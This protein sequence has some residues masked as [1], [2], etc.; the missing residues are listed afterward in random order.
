MLAEFRVKDF[1]SLREEAVISFIPSSRLRKTKS[2]IE[3]GC[4]EIPSLLPFLL[5][6]GDETEG[7]NDL[8]LALD[9]FFYYLEELDRHHKKGEDIFDTERYKNLIYFSNKFPRFEGTF[10]IEDTAIMVEVSVEMIHDKMRWKAVSCPFFYRLKQ[11]KEE[12]DFTLSKR[13]ITIHDLYPED[14]R[15]I[16]LL[17]V[18]KVARKDEDTINKTWEEIKDYIEFRKGS[19]C[20]C[21]TDDSSLMTKKEVRKDMIYFM[22]TDHRTMTTEVYSLMQF[23]EEKGDCKNNLAFLYEEGI[24]GAVPMISPKG[25]YDW[26][27]WR[28][29]KETTL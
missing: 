28:S 21:F 5:V 11:P 13:F 24:Y 19:Q 12:Q 10:V 7:R 25:H 18:F 20:L 17:E 2:L 22:D 6:Y 23:K 1:R 4:K 15:V 8:H 3:T 27:F 9:L 14:K 16:D 26:P 29:Y